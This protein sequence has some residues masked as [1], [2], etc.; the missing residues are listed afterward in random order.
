MRL[1][2]P[3]P[4]SPGRFPYGDRS[5][6]EGLEGALLMA[7]GR[8][9]RSCSPVVRQNMEFFAPIIALSE[10]KNKP[11]CSFLLMCLSCSLC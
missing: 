9:A 10:Q 3:L 7:E 6:R 5:S 8:L 11:G 2:H 4:A 1:L